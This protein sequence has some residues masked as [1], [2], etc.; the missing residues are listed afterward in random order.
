MDLGS[1]QKLLQFFAKKTLVIGRERK[2][3]AKQKSQIIISTYTR[4]SNLPK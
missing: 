4:T 1:S 3:E 2:S